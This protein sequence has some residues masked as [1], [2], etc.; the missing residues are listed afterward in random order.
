MQ[1]FQ[2][3]GLPRSGT[4]WIASVLNTIPNVYCYHEACVY[5]KPKD[6][7]ETTKG[8]DYIG[9]ASSAVILD[10][11]KAPVRIVIERDQFHALNATKAAFKSFEHKN[12]LEIVCRFAAWKMNADLVIPF[13]DLFT[14]EAVMDIMEMCCPSSRIDQGKLNQLIK[15]RVQLSDF[16]YN[17]TDIVDNLSDGKRAS[18]IA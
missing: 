5:G 6:V 1:T 8:F 4:A 7:L 3:G 9:D 14:G 2:I 12:W 11:Y 17:I 18:Q 13:G 15:M 16:N 10:D